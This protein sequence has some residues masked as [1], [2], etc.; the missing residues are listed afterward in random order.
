M[1]QLFPT[2]P[3]ATMVIRHVTPEIVT[4]SLPFARFGHLQFG[5]RGT[6]V[7]LSTGS[8]AVFSPVTLTPEV[9][10]T[11]ESLGGNVK[12]IAAPDLEHHLHITPW[13][14]AYPQAEI[15]A[16]EG[17]FEKRQSN[18]QFQD[19]LFEHI[20]KKSDPLPRTISKEF[21]AEFD[22][23]YVHGHGSRELVFLHKPSRT[24]IEADMLFNLPATE[25][26]SRTP[27]A[28]KIN[29]LTRILLPLM[30]TKPPATWHRRFAWYILSS[31]DRT[32]FNESVNRIDQWN[33]DR[34]IPCHGD[35]I[36]TGAK[37]IFRDVMA[38]HLAKKDN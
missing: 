21:D 12:Y 5:G 38:W 7:K 34:L 3:S 1:P 36:E 35:T 16:P 20:F 27:E 29:F 22:T 10:E 2:N 23:E 17:L 11:I 9:R 13:K 31:H 8:L 15:L 14:Q 26:Y 28:S 18:P 37:G 25:Q 6:L 4:M 24:L 19:T 30:S 32:A 33:F